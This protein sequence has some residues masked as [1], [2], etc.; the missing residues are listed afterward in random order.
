MTKINENL[1]NYYY[2]KLNEA[3]NWGMAGKALG[4]IATAVGLGELIDAIQAG[5]SP[6]DIKYNQ[7]GGGGRGGSK[8]GGGFNVSADAADALVSGDRSAYNKYVANLYNSGMSQNQI[9]GS[10][11]RTR[12]MA[13]NT[14]KEQAANIRATALKD[15][16]VKTAREALEAARAARDVP[17]GGPPDPARVADAQAAAKKLKEA[18]RAALEKTNYYDVARRRNALQSGGFNAQ[19]VQRGANPVATRQGRRAQYGISHDFVPRSL[20]DFN[21]LAQVDK[22]IDRREAEARAQGQELGYQTPAEVMRS[23]AINSGFLTKDGKINP[24]YG[25]KDEFGYVD[26]PAGRAAAIKAA[27]EEAKRETKELQDR[28]EREEKEKRELY[29]KDPKEFTK[30]YPNDV[31]TMEMENR[32]GYQEA[33]AAFLAAEEKKYNEAKRKQGTQNEGDNEIRPFV[34]RAGTPVS[35]VERTRTS[36]TPNVNLPP[37]LIPPTRY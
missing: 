12:A 31:E 5:M 25:L 22:D 3:P 2:N 7:A 34:D 15:P 18:E 19:P 20:D 21:R 11:I 17:G 30:R 14:A 37:R 23:M 4:G 36:R 9:T 6:E 13:A 26:T 1:I 27:R 35:A 33:L 8:S 16:A 28:I 10:A 24:E 32:P 29:K